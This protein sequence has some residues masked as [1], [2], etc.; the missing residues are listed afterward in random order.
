[1][2][3]REIALLTAAKMEH[4]G[5]QLTPAEVRGDDAIT[6]LPVEEASAAQVDTGLFRM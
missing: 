1:M 2:T 5:R 4:E 3:P 6:R